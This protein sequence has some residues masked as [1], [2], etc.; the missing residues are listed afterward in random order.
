MVYWVLQSVIPVFRYSKHSMR[1][2]STG[3]TV[4]IFVVPAL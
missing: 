1:C 4:I 2:H 3:F